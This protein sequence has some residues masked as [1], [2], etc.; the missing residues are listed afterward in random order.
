MLTVLLAGCTSAPANVAAPTPAP[1]SAVASTGA[2]L[3]VANDGDKLTSTGCGIERWDVKTLKDT[4][5]KQ[6]N[7][8]P[9]ATTVAALR[10]IPA[11]VMPTARVAAEM[12]TYTVSAT[13][14]SF[15]QEAD[16]DIHLAVK[17]DTGKTMI[18]E[19]PAKQCLDSSKTSPALIT[20]MT[21]SLRAWSAK[22]TA[23]PSYQTINQR[24]TVTGVLFFDKLHGQRGVAP[25]GAE[26]H[27]LL[28]LVLK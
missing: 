20:Q 18:F 7:F 27:P 28:S 17:D 11:P 23:T 5:A 13:V 6:I 16:S 10:L 22:Y 3:V 24:V 14:T 4:A 21:N 26:M 15:K 9:V 1:P 25:N 2:P 12:K 19:M 8:T